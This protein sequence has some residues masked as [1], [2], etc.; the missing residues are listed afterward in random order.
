M[1]EILIL[2]G[3]LLKG[4][5]FCLLPLSYYLLGMLNYSQ[6]GK[7][8]L[9]GFFILGTL[10]CWRKIWGAWRLLTF[11][12]G[13]SLVLL[14]ASIVFQVSIR[15]IF[16]MQQDDVLVV[17]ALLNTN[18]EEVRGFFSQYMRH[19]AVHLIFSLVFL[20]T[21]WRLLV[22]AGRDLTHHHPARRRR[23]TIIMALVMSILLVIIHS[24]SSLRKANPLFYFHYNYKKMSKFRNF[25]RF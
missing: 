14:T 4:V 7:A 1:K 6:A 25:W 21:Y 22:V 9:L 8:S 5:A 19:I 11:A 13:F 15:Q 18:L 20:A 10:F 2:V 3:P 12:L 23:T 17:Q 24:N 16:G